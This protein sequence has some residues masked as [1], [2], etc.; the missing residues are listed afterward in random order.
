MNFLKVFHSI[1]KLLI[2]AALL[3]PALA[4]NNPVPQIVGPVHPDAVAPGGGDFTFSVYGANFIPG[5]VV[6]WNYQ[7]RT[8]TFVSAHEIR[9]QILASDIS[10][11]TAGYITVTNPAPGGGSSSASWAQVEVHEPISTIVMGAPEYNLLSWLAEA[12]DVYHNTKLDLLGLY[13]G[14]VLYPNEANGTFESWSFVDPHYLGGPYQ[15]AYGDFNNDGNLDV[16]AASSLGSD[17]GSNPTRMDVM[18]G[19]GAGTFIAGT[20]ILSH[21]DNLNDVLVGD[22]NQDGNLDLIT[23]GVSYLTE[24]LGNGDGTFRLSVRY[25]YPAYGLAVQ[26]VAGDF[27]G[28]GKLDLLLLQAPYLSF[29]NN[30]RPGMAFWFMQGNGDGT[31]QPITEVASFPG[32]DVCGGGAYSG[33]S[34]QVSD[35][36]G[37][38]NLD[39]AF[40]NK[41]QIGVMLGNGDGT[42][43]SPNFYTAD[44]TNRGMYTF[45]VGDI[46][47]D[48]KPDLLVSEYPGDYGN[49]FVVFLGNGDGTFQ[50]PRTVGLAQVPNPE[51]GITVGDFNSDGLLDFGFRSDVGMDVFLQQ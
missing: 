10:H 49:T 16:A 44:F 3:T 14:L 41:S 21:E 19:N 34:L 4:Q 23:E 12:A 25:P 50:A 46:N 11:N 36:N 1:P 37:D 32:A 18:L 31:F 24:Y 30:S 9:A 51:T 27:N 42:F 6:N 45:A 28:D 2:L 40:C 39:I 29:N 43:Q 48:G 20:P 33:T 22:F 5:S 26:T 47:A 17:Y 13:D 38:G 15:F 7:P 8:T 35:F